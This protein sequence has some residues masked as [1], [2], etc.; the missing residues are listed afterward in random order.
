MIQG[1]DTT[2]GIASFETIAHAKRGR[3]LRLNYE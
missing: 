3:K 2:A 1:W